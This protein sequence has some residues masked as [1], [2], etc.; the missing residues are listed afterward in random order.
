MSH[1]ITKLLTQ[2]RDRDAKKFNLTI[3]IE[4]SESLEWVILTDST[5]KEMAI[6][7]IRREFRLNC[8]EGY[9]KTGFIQALETPKSPEE[10][11]KIIRAYFQHGYTHVFHSMLDRR[12][13][14][15][16][17]GKGLSMAEFKRMIG[18]MRK[19]PPK[20]KPQHLEIPPS[21]IKTVQAKKASQ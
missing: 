3:R 14:D 9:T 10:C 19:T 4:R 2:I 11:R 5:K 21:L 12:C 7:H 8:V 6:C 17:K 18:R 20:K 1:P 13:K 15:A 16:K